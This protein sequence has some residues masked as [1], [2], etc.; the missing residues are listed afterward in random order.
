MHGLDPRRYIRDLL[1][2]IAA[3]W[4][5]RALRALLP[6]AWLAAHPDAPCSTRPA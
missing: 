6:D 5:Q 2:R 4:P 1:E 3:G